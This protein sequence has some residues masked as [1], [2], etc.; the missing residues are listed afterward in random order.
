M[1]K[2]EQII[3][4]NF[5]IWSSAVKSKS[6]VGRG[7]SSKIELYG[8][9]KL[10]ELILDLA[11]RGLLVP[12]DPNDE[13]ASELLKKIASEKAKLIKEGKIKKEK[14]LE[15]I[16]KDDIPF[17]IP[18]NWEWVRLDDICNY[19]QRGKSPEYSTKEEIPVIA[20]KCIQWSGIDMN[21]A[22]FINPDSI[23]KYANERL[24][25]SEDLLWNSTGNGTLGRINI[26]YEYMSKYKIIVADSHV[27][28][29]RVSKI[30]ISSK[31]IL[32][33]LSGSYV[34]ENLNNIITGSTKQT[35]LPINKVKNHIVPL[36]PLEEQK[37]IV[38]K[39]DE[40]MTLCDT[41][42]EKI[43]ISKELQVKLAEVCT[44]PC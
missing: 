23:N 32:N 34:Q 14:P 33:W 37:R 4:Q 24:I 15:P 5:D 38:A 39:V 25:Q 26:Y 29:I 31:Y 11:V 1:S 8:V 7:S 13:P 22:Q 19:I 44:H 17:V 20:Q 3:T 16:K 43:S 9:K 41:L 36:P 12:Q 18:K 21:K 2:F 10:R 30:G 35:E 42:K 27:T 40:L 28:V 6:S